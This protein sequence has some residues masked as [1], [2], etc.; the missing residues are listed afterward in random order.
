MFE[1]SPLGM[2]LAEG[3]LLDTGHNLEIGEVVKS[4]ATP[5]SGPLDTDFFFFPV[6]RVENTSAQSL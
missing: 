4:D 2:R 6:S 1:D 5:S 3:Q